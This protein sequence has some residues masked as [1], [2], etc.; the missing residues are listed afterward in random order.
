M[1]TLSLVAKNDSIQQGIAVLQAVM[2]FIGTLIAIF[3]KKKGS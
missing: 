1:D 3:G 2:L